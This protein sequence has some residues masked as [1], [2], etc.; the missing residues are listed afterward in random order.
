[1]SNFCIELKIYG[2]KYEAEKDKHQSLSSESYLLNDLPNRDNEFAKE[3]EA[4]SRKGETCQ[5]WTYTLL[6]QLLEMKRCFL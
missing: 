3:L 4:C 1:M 2:T 6:K 5:I